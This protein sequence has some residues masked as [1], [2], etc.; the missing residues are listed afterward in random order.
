MAVDS[1]LE[2]LLQAKKPVIFVES[3][4]TRCNALEEVV[5][6]SELIGARVYQG[7][8]SDVNFPVTH[9]QY[10]GDLNPTEPQA[11]AALK[12]VDVVIGI[13]C[14]LFDQGF[15]NPAWKLP[16]DIKFIQIDENP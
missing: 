13:G 15:Y 16:W 12:S 14:S 8:M 7:W 10:L 2:T 5:R 4:V 3:G 6:F 1:S 9:P 11:E